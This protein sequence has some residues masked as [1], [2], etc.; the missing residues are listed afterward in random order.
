M[1]YTINNSI[2]QEQID[3]VFSYI[4]TELL[5]NRVCYTLNINKEDIFNSISKEEIKLLVAT[6]LIN[7]GVNTKDLINSLFNNVSSSILNPY[8]LINAKEAAD[9]ITEYCKSSTSYIYIFADYDCDGINSGFIAHDVISKVSKG[10]VVVFYP[11]RKD[12]YGLSK[13]WCN[14]IIKKHTSFE[15][16]ALNNEVLVITVDNGIT[17]HEEVKLLQ[18]AGIECIITD[19]HTSKIGEVPDCI[20]V[21]PHNS[22]IKQGDTYKHL[23]GTSVIFKV[24]QLIQENFGINTMM[25]YTPNVAIATLSDVM[26]MTNENSAFIQYGLEIMNGA[27]CPKGIQALKELKGINTLTANDINWTIAP[28]I[29]ACGRMGNTELASQL[30]FGH[31]TKTYE[32]IIKEIDKTNEDRKKLTKDAQKEIE[33]MNFDRHKVCIVPSEKYPVGIVG[34]IAGK[35]A[36]RFNKPAIVVRKTKSGLYHGSIRSANKINMISLL[37]ELKE[38]NLID[39]Y[40]GHSEAC[41][42]GFDIKNLNKVQEYLDSSIEANEIINDTQLLINKE[43]I[44]IDEVI[45]IN[46]FNEI[47]HAIVNLLPCDNRQYKNPTFSLNDLT[48]KSHK[49]F[50]SGYT[51][52]IFKHGK[53]TIESS[54]YSDVAEKFFNE[55]LPNMTD[56]TFTVNI[57]GTI[58]KRS[59]FSSK[60][61]KKV[62]T[63]NIVDIMNS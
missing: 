39:S 24:C 55:V 52:I 29:N 47:V 3:E 48:I 12:G 5:L 38:L 62:F 28:M 41:V 53:D 36:E 27:N 26:P 61:Q 4:D 21:N 32:T 7:R 11:N 35:I 20:V 19:H 42:C 2:N 30:F 60:F 63:L 33:V 49:Q 13:K 17:K 46:H 25:D 43:T 14:D 6:I 51:E 1:S 31:K 45:T 8:L 44:L 59:F 16:R 10:K 54:V 15:D 40:G 18:N 57:I 9:K 58:D 56:K 50:K 22:T 34:I 23:C 37:K